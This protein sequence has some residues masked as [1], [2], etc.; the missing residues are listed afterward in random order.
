MASTNQS[1][2]FLSAQKKYYQAIKGEDK[3]IALEE[4][5]S[6]CPK[7]KSAESL[8]A[9]IRTRIKKLKEKLESK[10]KQKKSIARKQGIKK[11]GIQVVLCGFTNSGKSS[12]LAI[13][14]NAKPKISPIEFTT[15][16][17]I[18]GTLK[19]QDLNFQII[20]LPAINHET[21][22]QGIANSADILLVL[23]KNLNELNEILPFLNK[24]TGKRIIVFNKSDLLSEEEKRK[25]EATLKSNKYNFVLISCKTLEGIE[26]L[27]EKLIENSQV[28]RIYTK[29]PHKPQDKEPVILK[30]QATIKDL[31]E[32][33]FHSKIKIKEI[34]I[35]GPSSKFPNQ[36]VGLKHQLKDKD[37]VEFHTY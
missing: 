24:S 14:T 10:Q 6:F 4:M 16:E 28:I 26:E 20:D 17:E 35:T 25:I 15:Q 9:N 31:S 21:F 2:E 12:L 23:I 29:Q 13:L 33:I 18:L 3:L 19:Y 34:R 37:V 22:D 11:Q 1:P 36:V 27:K 7:H 30:P 8:R 32:K 5:W